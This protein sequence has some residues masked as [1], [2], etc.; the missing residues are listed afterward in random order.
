MSSSGGGALGGCK[1]TNHIISAIVTSL[2]ILLLSVVDAV[3]NVT[4]C[5]LL[6]LSNSQSY[7]CCYFCFYFV[8]VQQLSM[9][10]T[11][12][13]H[14]LDHHYNT[15]TF[16]V[17]SMFMPLMARRHYPVNIFV[18]TICAIC[19]F[20]TDSGVN[21]RAPNR[22]IWEIDGQA[23]SFARVETTSWTTNVSNEFYPLLHIC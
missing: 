9:L 14:Y 11:T 10:I 21:H 7:Y 19:T 15:I 8:C 1:D 20:E 12:V 17:T 5:Q 6:S 3:V 2:A 18:Q 13:C 23:C 16:V 4:I 22:V